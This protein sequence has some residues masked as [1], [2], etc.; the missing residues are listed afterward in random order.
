MVLTDW[1]AR[2]GEIGSFIV[3]VGAFLWKVVTD[4]E[5]RHER[6]AKE[7]AAKQLAESTAV[8]VGVVGVK[9]D[10]NT[11]ITEATHEIAD[12][13]LSE[14][15]KQLADSREDLARLVAEGVARGAAD[16]LT[17]AQQQSMTLL[18]EAEA[19]ARKVIAEAEQ[20]AEERRRHDRSRGHS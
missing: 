6:R 10:Q 2:L 3:L 19:R 13:R 12:G 5:D 7:G 15:L 17:K 9:M 18:A 1:P 20:I 8:A 14:A 4:I 16:L 11:A